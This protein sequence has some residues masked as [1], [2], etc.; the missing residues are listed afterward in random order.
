MLDCFSGIA[1]NPYYMTN[2]NPLVLAVSSAVF[3]LKYGRKAVKLVWR[4][5]KKQH[6]TAVLVGWKITHLNQPRCGL[7]PP[8]GLHVNGKSSS[9]FRPGGALPV[10]RFIKFQCQLF[11]ADKISREIPLDS[12]KFLIRE[13]VG[14]KQL[15]KTMGFP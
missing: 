5:P 1:L 14:S 11:L 12:K 2:R 6:C 7:D 15:S 10:R 4:V 8:F 3:L 9:S 13:N